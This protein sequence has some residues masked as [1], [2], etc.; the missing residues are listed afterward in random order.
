MMN[1]ALRL[2]RVYHDLS[3]SDAAQ[4][5]GL[6]KSY[7]SEIERGRKKVSL[8]VL[9]KYSLA[10]DIPISSMMLFAE[11]IEDGK[12]SEKSRAY[13]ADKALKMLDWIATITLNDEARNHVD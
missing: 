11:R 13:V 7:I 9:T 2:I 6:S 5:I 4:R 10:F 12:F 3:L 1:R 8:E